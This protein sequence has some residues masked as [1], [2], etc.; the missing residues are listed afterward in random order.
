LDRSRYK[1]VKQGDIAEAP[2][3]STV[4]KNLNYS[5]RA[6]MYSIAYKEINPDNHKQNEISSE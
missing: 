2:D 4:G 6:E 1:W 5:I 3:F